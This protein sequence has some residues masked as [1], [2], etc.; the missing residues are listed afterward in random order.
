MEA[1]G[2]A[3]IRSLIKIVRDI[4]AARCTQAQQ[5]PEAAVVQ[6]LPP[7]V[8]HPATD[9]DDLGEQYRHARDTLS[10]TIQ[11]LTDEHTAA[12]SGMQGEFGLP[13]LWQIHAGWPMQE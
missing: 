12:S 6:G 4:V 5:Q 1:E 13:L 10:E 11:L 2:H 9:L 7:S 3:Q 8:S